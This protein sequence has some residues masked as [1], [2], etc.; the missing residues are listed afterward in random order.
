M[1]REA[2]DASLT[3]GSRSVRSPPQG[4]TVRSPYAGAR[5]YLKAF[6]VS[7]GCTALAF[8]LYPSFNITNIAMLY[9][10][11]TVLAA[12]RWGRGPSVLTCFVNVLALDYFFIPPIFSFEISDLPYFF[13]LAAQLVVALVVT[14]L[15][16]RLRL[17]FERAEAARARTAALYALSSELCTAVDIDAIAS[18]AAHHI[19][20]LL[21]VR[22]DVMMADAPCGLSRATAAEREIARRVMVSGRRH[23]E[24][25]VH[26]P[27]G[28][29]RRWHGVLI[30]RPPATTTLS[31]EQLDLLDAVTAPLSLAVQRACLASENERARL[32]TERATLR[33]TL[34]ASISH[35]L[36]T[37]LTAIAGAASLMAR[38]DATLNAERRA[39]LGLLIERKAGDMSQLLNN[40]LELVRMESADFALR[41]DWYAV[42]ELLEHSLRATAEALARHHIVNELR[43]D[44]PLIRVDAT[45]FVQIL[46]N[47]LGNAA[48]HT[49]PGTTVRIGATVDQGF[50]A[51]TVTDDGPGLPGP[52]TDRLFDKFQRGQEE[53][54]VPG[55]GLGLSICRA[56]ARLHGG[57]IGVPHDPGRTGACFEVRVPIAGVEPT[58]TAA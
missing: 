10:L 30:V 12:L 31:P 22:A 28:G 8:P 43:P 53:T 2:V 1:S 32:E 50:L 14:N 37:P 25:A 16:T 9:L 13:T 39:T 47:L 49:P 40:V 42:D 48:K 56:A 26:V 54:N 15:L 4:A 23:V 52:S 33:N 34:L 51:L 38:A 27:L 29:P 21:D 17:Q 58:R 24:G 18:A 11:G 6:A 41:A 36:R 55:V 57:E 19:E 46:D 35:D 44:L 3:L 45:L 20:R 7:A 5:A